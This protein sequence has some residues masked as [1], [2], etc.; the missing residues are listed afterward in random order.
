MSDLLRFLAVGLFS[1]FFISCNFFKKDN[2]L[3]L[4]SPLQEIIIP[5][6]MKDL[7]KRFS[8]EK[9]NNKIVIINFWA[10]WC[11]PCQEEMPSL[12]KLVSERS[13]QITLIA[14][15]TDNSE[16]EMKKFM[17]LFPNF[18]GENIYTFYDGGRNW[19]QTYSVTGFPET[20]IY[21]QNHKFLKRYQGAMDFKSSEFLK[22]ISNPYKN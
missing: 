19:I 18:K 15:N 14:I 20:F 16:K 10:S 7:E 17:G 5:E 6:G 12:L 2:V 21:D 11:A 22:L 8:L 3:L 9:L 4:K 1:F 13:S